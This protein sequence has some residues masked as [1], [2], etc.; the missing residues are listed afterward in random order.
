MRET[1]LLFDGSM[2]DNLLHDLLEGK[3]HCCM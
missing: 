2:E 1:F 3:Y